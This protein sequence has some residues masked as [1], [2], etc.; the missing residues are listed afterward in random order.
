MFRKIMVPLDGS[1]EAE[2]ILPYVSRIASGMDL[3]VALLS[4]MD[5]GAMEMRESYY[6]RLFERA[7]QEAKGRLHN[8]AHQ[9]QQDGV[10]TE[11]L[12]ISGRAD[13]EITEAADRIGCNLIAMSTRG[14]SLLGRGILGS[15]ADRVVHTARIPVLTV[16]P[17]KVRAY[18]G[19]DTVVTRLVVPL[20]GSALAETVLPYVKEMASKLGYT[21]VLL[22]VVR[23]LHYFWVGEHPPEINEENAL[24]ENEAREYMEATAEGLSRDGVA[25]EWRVLVG[26][27]TTI[28]LEQIRDI[29]HSIVALTTHGS[30][31]LRRW[32]IGSLAET[33]VRSGGDPVL[34][35]PPPEQQESAGADA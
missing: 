35:V 6:S 12:V 7:E 5:R 30:S 8:A 31:S 22:R 34:I 25:V 16:T 33:L 13:A 17:G 23:P 26:H 18:H 21:V 24:M 14:R 10:R 19:S 1:D 20:D 15:V 32:L 3:A 29:P 2:A 9:L 28:V 27:P 11:E 4:V